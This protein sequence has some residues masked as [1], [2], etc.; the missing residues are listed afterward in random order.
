M[1]D[2]MQMK[3]KVS[4]QSPGDKVKLAI[5]LAQS[6]VK[7]TWPTEPRGWLEGCSSIEDQ[8]RGAQLE[9]SQATD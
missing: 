3:L 2:Q 7:K 5:L 9:L 8:G 6:S 4:L 1:D